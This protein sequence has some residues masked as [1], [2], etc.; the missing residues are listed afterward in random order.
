MK[1]VSRDILHKSDAGGVA[2]DLLNENEVLDAYEA[3]IQ[4]SLSYNP[5]ATIDG[6]EIS[7]M[8]ERGIEL[9]IG[10]RMD[11]A[12]G[13]IV[14]CGM[15]GIYVEVIKDVVF[16]SWPIDTAEAMKMLKEIRSFPLLLGVR[17][18]KKKDIDGVIDTIMRVGSII[19]RCHKVTD[20]E[21]NPVVVFEKSKG[22]R[23]LDVRILIK[24]PEEGK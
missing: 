23:A 21:I 24:N 9:I 14:M 16:R 4:N 22:L 8:I 12:F 7:E 17:G 5:R 2:L 6:I 15:G 18:E 3:I 13:P 11:R 20:I 1:V 10:A 19:K